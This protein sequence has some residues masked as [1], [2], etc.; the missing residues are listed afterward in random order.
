MPEATQ[1][2]SLF[3]AP[4]FV[5]KRDGVTKQSFDIDK[6]GAAVRKA[7]MD[8]KTEIDES[9]LKRI[10]N[11][12]TRHFETDEVA[13]E[14]VQDIVELALMKF[15]LHAVAK[16]Y[17]LYRQ[18][19]K[20]IR[21][22]RLKPDPT[23]ISS[24]IHPAKYARYLPTE[25][26]RELFPETVDRV[27]GMHLRRFSHL[28]GADSKLEIDIRWAFDQVREKRI[29]PSMRTLQFGGLAVEAINARAYNCC[30]TYIDRPR[31][32]SEILYLL[33]CGCGVGY[34]VQTQH[35]EN[36]PL[37]KTPDKHRVVHHEIAD[38]IEGWANAIHELVMSYVDGYYVEFAYHLIR[39]AGSVLKTSGGKAPGHLFLK[40]SLE[41][42]RKILE[43]AVGRKLRSIECHDIVC[44]LADAVLSGGIRRSALIALFSPEDIEMMHAKTGNWYSRFPWRANA[45]NSAVLLRS[46]TTRKEFRSIFKAVKEWGEPGFYFTNSLNYLTNPCAE[47]GMYP[48]DE[49]TRSSGFSF[50]NLVEING[51]KVLSEEDFSTAVRAATI[52]GTLQASYTEFPYLGTPTENITR[53]DALLGVGITGMLDSP[54][55]VLN[56][57]MQRRMAA[58]VKEVNKEIAERIG[59]NPAART[60]CVKPSGSTS[61]ALGGVGSGHHAHHAR[62][63]IRRVTANEKENVFQY[64]KSINPHMCVRKP[65]GDWVIE[66]PVE[67]PPG[68]LI[69]KDLSALQFLEMVRSTQKNWVVE[70]NG[71]SQVAADLYH[72]VSNTVTVRPE[73][74]DAVAD[75]IWTHREDFTGVSLLADTGD[76]DYSFSPNEEIV[77]SA[78]EIR[79]N[80]LLMLYKPVDY[81]MMLETEDGT[82]LSGEAACAGGACSI[83]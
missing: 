42:V 11:W 71:Q 2:K 6:I 4:S 65:N 31:V 25:F 81:G 58:L 28:F 52:I 26:R 74:W 18:E 62:R 29:L 20:L 16:Q 75:Y 73:E 61:L 37:L 72:N 55:I 34:S 68:A 13:V 9:L 10:S 1:P 24:Y 56:P 41:A 57:S 54:D 23:A 33:L 63:Y 22:Q 67:A 8:T 40:D 19:R 64:F 77:T 80:Q 32:F 50:C 38:T 17:I 3:V 78:D 36:L 7:W 39:P 82:N 43:G 66:F 35:V 27:E 12:V 76:K 45:N 44:I 79:W 51:A 83:T 30:S 5:L 60:T 14:E 70:G 49:V 53:R 48:F 15:K 69:R 59:I 46:E 21:D 47:I